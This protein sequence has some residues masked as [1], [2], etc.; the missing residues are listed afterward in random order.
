MEIKTI[1]SDLIQ[2]LI[3]WRT[4]W[5]SYYMEGIELEN[6]IVFLKTLP[7][8]SDLLILYFT[9]ENKELYMIGRTMEDYVKIYELIVNDRTTNYSELL[10]QCS[11]YT[12]K[13]LRI[14]MNSQYKNII[15]VYVSWGFDILIELMMVN[16]KFNR[17]AR[18]LV[19]DPFSLC[20]H[21]R[22]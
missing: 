20:P 21:D 16:Y 19:I 8:Y 4:R 22:S 7:N 2:T 14:K 13:P 15:Q 12:N 5:G 17:L 11:L 18:R 6:S 9:F 10:Y 3:E 1:T